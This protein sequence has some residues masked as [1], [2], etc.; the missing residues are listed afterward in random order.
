M[1]RIVGSA[2][3]REI[4]SWGQQYSC[5][6]EQEKHIHDFGSILNFVEYAFGIGE[7]SPNYEYADHFAP[8]GLVVCGSK[9]PHPYALSDFFPSFTSPRTF[10]PLTAPFTTE[11]FIVPNQQN[12]NGKNFT[13]PEDPDADDVDEQD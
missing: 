9:C 6:N 2:L 4:R 7:I 1:V 13:G 8:D 11:C 10:T 3:G 12:C 5:P